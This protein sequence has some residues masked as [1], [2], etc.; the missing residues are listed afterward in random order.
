MWKMN[1]KVFD[2][3]RMQSWSM[4]FTGY[5]TELKSVHFTETVLGVE[6]GALC[7][8]LQTVRLFQ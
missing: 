2:E 4:D 7:P 1:W 6:I 3:H 8:F 5:G